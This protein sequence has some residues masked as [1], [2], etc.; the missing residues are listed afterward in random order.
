MSK[1]PTLF[2]NV[3]CT[4]L[5][6]SATAYSQQSNND[7]TRVETFIGYTNFQSEGLPNRNTPG[8][9]FDNG[10]FRNR[11]TQHG[12]NLAVSGFA[13]NWFSLTGDVS[14][15]RQSESRSTTAGATDSTRTDTWYFLGGPTWKIRKTFHLEPFTR[16]MAGAAHTHYR[17]ATSTPL[18]GGTTT[19]SFKAGSTDF[20]AS[21]G[22]GFDI[23][24]G[25]HTKLRALQ[26]DWAPIFLRD[27]TINVLGSAGAL[28]PTTLEGQRQDN[29]RFSFGVVF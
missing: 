16:I 22:G 23:R 25:P 4:I 1:R 19:S 24:L 15:A 26:V 8:W 5:L 27:R 28:E 21:L 20:A 12:V 9:I 17:V 29:V 14:F 13:T 10:F 2:W 6:A 11:S 18:G 3:V 7:E